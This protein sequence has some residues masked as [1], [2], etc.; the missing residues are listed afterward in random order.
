V[1]VDRGLREQARIQRVIGMVVAQDHV[2]DVLR[3]DAERGQRIEDRLR[4][5]G[6]ARIDHD[7]PVAVANQGARAL[8]A[9]ARRGQRP[10]QDHVDL[11]RTAPRNVHRRGG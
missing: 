10:I 5:R 4:A 9:A 3:P 2:G 1:V 8:D 6:H 11:R 7:H